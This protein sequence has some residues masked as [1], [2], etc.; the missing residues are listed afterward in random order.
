MEL[1]AACVVAVASLVA[2]VLLIWGDRNRTHTAWMHSVHVQDDCWARANRQ[3]MTDAV[4]I[5][6]LVQANT[7]LTK[8]NTELIRQN[9]ELSSLRLNFAAMQDEILENIRRTI[10]KEIRPDSETHVTV[11]CSGSNDETT[12]ITREEMRLVGVAGGNGG[13]AR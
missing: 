2:V 12:R 13:G 6:E 10:T 11:P 1:L 4:K 9:T 7:L 3:A 8:H 5:K